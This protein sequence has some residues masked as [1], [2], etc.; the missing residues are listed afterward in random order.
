MALP[1]CHVMVQFHVDVEEGC[2]DAKLTQRSGDM[3]LGVPFNIASYSFLLHIIGNLTGYT[4]RHFIHDI[5]DGHIYENHRE[6][7]VKQLKRTTHDFPELKIKRK[8][9]SI[10]DIEESD[11][12]ILN[13]NHHGTIK[14]DMVA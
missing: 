3:F 9:E 1:P 4:P 10:D 5:G 7:I 8:L 2:L 12:E 11:F 6:A 14:A 13:Y